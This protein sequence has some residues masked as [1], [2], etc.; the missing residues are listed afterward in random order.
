MARSLL[1]QLEQIRRSATYTDAV[2][3]VNTSTVAEPTVSGSLQDD[4]NVIRNKGRQFFLN[5][6]PENF[7]RL[8]HDYSDGRKGFVVWKGMVERLMEKREKE[9]QI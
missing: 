5:N 8:M 4:L 7:S 1:R 3:S 2:V 6:Q 9:L